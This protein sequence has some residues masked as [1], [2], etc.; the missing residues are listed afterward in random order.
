MIARIPLL[1]LLAVCVGCAAPDPMGEFNLSQLVQT[2]P[3]DLRQV[4]IL[5]YGLASSGT[6][7]LAVALDSTDPQLSAE[8]RFDL[9]AL[10]AQNDTANQRTISTFG[11]ATAD[12]RRFA[13][14]QVRLR[15]ALLTGTP[16]RPDLDGRFGTCDEAGVQ[17]RDSAVQA[18]LRDAASGRVIL[19]DRL[20]AADAA[21]LKAVSPYCL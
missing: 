3:A 21:R 6:S 15:A 2:D 4:V 14:L 11:L 12:Y 1:A 7:A 9:V 19:S 16:V 8:A 18:I 20:A 10:E 13:E 17:L 5:P